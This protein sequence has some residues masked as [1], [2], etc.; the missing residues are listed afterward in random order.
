MG[1]TVGEGGRINF[2]DPPR[3]TRATRE[4]G[5]LHVV[6]IAI[7]SPLTLAIGTLA[8]IVVTPFVVIG[9]IFDYNKRK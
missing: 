5:P 4:G 6:A 7:L 9:S 2:N 1:P 8:M 3:D